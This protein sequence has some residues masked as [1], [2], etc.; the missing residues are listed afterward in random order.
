ML[1]VSLLCTDQ[2]HPIFPRLLSWKEQFQTSYDIEIISEVEELRDIGDFLFLI[3][4][5]VLIDESIKSRFINTLVLHASDLPH[6]R[7]WSPHIWQ[8]IEG[9]SYI[10]LTL[11]EAAEEVDSGKIWLKERVDIQ[12]SDLFDEINDKLFDA[13]LRLIRKAI[14]HSSRIRPYTQNDQEKITYYRKRTPEDSRID[15]KSS[16]EKQ[17]NLFRVCDP[18]RYPAFFDLD[19]CRF[20]VEIKKVEVKNEKQQ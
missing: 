17:F 9:E 2:K 20:T 16:I 15:V 3:S 6:G 11:L 10:T 19:G 5:S 14:E 7:G 8:I 4:C 12:S 18:N 13:E 1:K